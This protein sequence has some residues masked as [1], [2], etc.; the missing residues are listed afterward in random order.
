MTQLAHELYM[1]P[2]VMYLTLDLPS[3]IQHTITKLPADLQKKLVANIMLTGGNCALTGLASRL[4][5]DLQTTL[6]EL[7]PWVWVRIRDAYICLRSDAV[8]GV[9]Y[10]PRPCDLGKGSN[11]EGFTWL[12]YVSREDYIIHGEVECLTRMRDCWEVTVGQTP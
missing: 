12:P 9:S 5:L 6:T 1:A 10:L 11:E 8:E 4:Q 3:M 7:A 2:E